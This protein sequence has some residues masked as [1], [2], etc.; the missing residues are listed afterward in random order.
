M[1]DRNG[2]GKEGFV[3]FEIVVD[4]EE[5]GGADLQLLSGSRTDSE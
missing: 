4:E 5:G 3:R 1:L 2:R